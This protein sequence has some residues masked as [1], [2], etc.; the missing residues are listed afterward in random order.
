MLFSCGDGWRSTIAA[1]RVRSSSYHPVGILDMS[2]WLL[3]AQAACLSII[4]DGDD[5]D[6]TRVIESRM[7]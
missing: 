6:D 2:T 4:L 7:G 1:S 5:D 3:V